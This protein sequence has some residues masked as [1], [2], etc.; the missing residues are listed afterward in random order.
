MSAGR[1]CR[2]LV[3][4]VGT[5]QVKKTGLRC[6]SSRSLRGLSHHS[7]EAAARGAPS[8]LDPSPWTP[9]KPAERPSF[10]PGAPPLP[11]SLPG[12][13]LSSSTPPFCPFSTS[14][15]GRSVTPF[16]PQASPRSEV[17]CDWAGTRRHRAYVSHP[18][19]LSLSPE[20]LHQAALGVSVSP[21]GCLAANT[22]SSRQP[23]VKTG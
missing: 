23:A 14:P 10:L 5:I 12:S 7:L 19:Q 17:K 9:K 2:Q 11:P 15:P 13:L 1:S 22:C 4:S 6:C 20:S 3:H 16:C 21:R 8:H 18:T